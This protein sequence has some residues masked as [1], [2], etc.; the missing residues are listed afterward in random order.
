LFCGDARA[1]WRQDIDCRDIG[2]KL[3]GIKRLRVEAR[4]AV[5]GF[6]WLH[7]YCSQRREIDKQR[8]LRVE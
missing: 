2:W 4:R 1:V 6:F 3:S 7:F 8:F 5:F